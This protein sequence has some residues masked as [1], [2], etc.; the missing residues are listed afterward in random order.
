MNCEYLIH[1]LYLQEPTERQKTY[2]EITEWIYANN[3]HVYLSQNEVGYAVSRK[4]EVDWYWDVF[5]FGFVGIG[6]GIPEAGIEL[7]PDI[8]LITVLAIGGVAV[9]AIAVYVFMRKRSK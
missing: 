5:N 7:P 9:V 4:Y 1:S 8:V 2:N 3:P 6:P